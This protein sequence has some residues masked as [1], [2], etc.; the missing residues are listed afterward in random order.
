M[1][2]WKVN[3]IKASLMERVLNHMEKQGY[4]V[5]TIIAL[6]GSGV[7]SAEAPLE[8]LLAGKKEIRGS[9]S[10]NQKGMPA[11][12]PENLSVVYGR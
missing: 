12:T 1:F 10:P 3:Q 6:P 2:E 4:E 9:S 7:D 11:V 8:V 5:Q